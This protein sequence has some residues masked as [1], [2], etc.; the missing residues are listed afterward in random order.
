MDADVR[1][2]AGR[3]AGATLRAFHKDAA[4]I[5]HCDCGALT[6]IWRD[7]LAISW[8]E[9]YIHNIFNYLRAFEGK[10]LQQK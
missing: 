2:T 4:L 5:L 9:H 10:S 3:G 7:R 6:G 8:K 1:I